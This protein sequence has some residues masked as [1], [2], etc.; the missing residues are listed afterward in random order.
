[1]ARVLLQEQA[2]PSTPS[3]N[4]V[5]LYPKAGGHWFKMS[6]DGLE[7][8]LL[9]LAGLVIRPKFTRPDVDTLLIDSGVYHHAGTT[10]Q[11][12]YWNSQLTYDFANLATSDWSYL[13]LDDSAIVTAATNVITATQLIDATTEPA[14]S[15]S[16]HGWYNSLDRCIFAVRT[17][18]SGNILEF[19]HENGYVLFANNITIDNVVDID[20]IYTDS[21]A[22]TL[23]I[24]SRE[25][26]VTIKHQHGNESCHLSWRTNGQLGGTGHVLLYA[27]PS[28]VQP[29]VVT[30]LLTGSA[31]K[32]EYKIGTAD[33]TNIMTV[34]QHGWYFP[35]GM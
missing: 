26:L 4:M 8:P 1:M 21:S 25:P 35:I 13:Y 2:T 27:N 19:F 12:L 23:P 3:A 16:K 33:N 34:W 28:Q 14:Y 10:N 30:K 31:H 17:D 5:A 11:V 24:F 20:E 15:Q 32:V 29:H 9:D 22:F 18:G 6:D 7:K